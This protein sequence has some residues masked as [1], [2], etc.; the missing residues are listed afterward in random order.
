[1]TDIRWTSWFY[2]NKIKKKNLHYYFLFFYKTC[3]KN[4]FQ[5]VDRTWKNDTLVSFIICILG[6]KRELQAYG[7]SETDSGQRW[8]SVLTLL[9][10]FV[11]Q[12]KKNKK[13][14]QSFVRRDS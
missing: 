10:S 7:T 11:K 8:L 9:Q 12:K 1:M 6:N 13:H 5:Y 14:P 2:E 3:L 4:F